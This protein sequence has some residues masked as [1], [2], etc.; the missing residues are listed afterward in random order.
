MTEIRTEIEIDAGKETVWGVLTDFAAYPDW[1][2]FLLR[3]DTRAHPGTPVAMTVKVDG[4]TMDADARVLSVTENRLLRWAGPLSAAKALFFRGEHYFVIQEL[5]PGRVRFVH[6]EE[7]T[8]ALIPLLGWWLH[9]RVAP[10]YHAYNAA[11]KRRAEER[12]VRRTAG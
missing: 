10:S 2:P 3:V 8:G 12:S 11:L 1:N 9:R 5:T 4:R 6:G 7:F